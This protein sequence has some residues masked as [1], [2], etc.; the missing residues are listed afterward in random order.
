MIKKEIRVGEKDKKENG[1]KMCEKRDIR[2]KGKL[3]EECKET[4]VGESRGG[5]KEKKGCN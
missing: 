2:K 3:V 5:K 4:K 1:K